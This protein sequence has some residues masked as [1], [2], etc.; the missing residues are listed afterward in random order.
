LGD[1]RLG[2]QSLPLGGRSWLISTMKRQFCQLWVD[3]WKVK[4]HILRLS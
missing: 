3:S 4:H 2:Q 1:V